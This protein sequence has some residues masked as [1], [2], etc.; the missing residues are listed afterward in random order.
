VGSSKVHRHHLR[1]G[2]DVEAVSDCAAPQGLGKSDGK[3]FEEGIDDAKPWHNLGRRCVTAIQFADRRFVQRTA[4]VDLEDLGVTVVFP[5]GRC[6][7]W[8]HADVAR[9][10]QSLFA[11]GT[12]DLSHHLGGMGDVVDDERMIQ[13]GLGN[14]ERRFL[15]DG[16]VKRTPARILTVGEQLVFRPHRAPVCLADG[17]GNPL[18]RH[19]DLLRSW[20]GSYTLPPD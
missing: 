4:Q 1:N 11:M 9:T 18:E 10:Q 17:K 2:V 15:E 14:V 6:P 19:P 20:F 13:C 5:F 8:S 3:L 12:F 16:G 7:R